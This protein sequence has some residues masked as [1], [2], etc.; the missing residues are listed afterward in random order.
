MGEEEREKAKE[1]GKV[2]KGLFRPR[3]P[4]TLLTLHSSYV[5]PGLPV[6]SATMHKVCKL[7]IKTS[8]E[9]IFRAM[10]E[11]KGSRPL[12]FAEV[13]LKKSSQEAKCRT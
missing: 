2:S 8:V 6:I 9:W 10:H 13:E 1:E 7:P 11:R 12:D 4:N 5:K 3:I